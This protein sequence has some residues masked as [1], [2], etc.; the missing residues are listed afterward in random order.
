M[1]K[2]MGMS[3][4]GYW[5]STFA[6]HFILLSIICV[7]ISIFC[8]VPL[9]QQPYLTHC[10]YEIFFVFMLAFAAAS[11]VFCLV[12][13]TVC[14]R[15]IVAVLVIII[16]WT[17]S[18]VPAF[19]HYTVW[20]LSDYS[21]L[22]KLSSC[23]FSP[24]LGLHLGLK[25]IQ[26]YTTYGT[27]CGCIPYDPDEELTMGAVI[28]TMIA[29]CFFYG[30][31]IWYLD[32]VWPWQP[33]GVPRP[34]YFCFEEFKKGV[35]SVNNASLNIYSGEITAL[36]GHNGAGKTTTMNMITGRVE[37]NGHDIMTDTKQARKSLGLCPQH[38][39]LY[40]FMTVA[41][42][43]RFYANLKGQDP[44]ETEE[45]IQSMLSLLHLTE[46]RNVLASELSGG[47]QRKLCLGIAVIGGSK[48]IILDEPTAGMDPEARRGVWDMLLTLRQSGD[49]TILLTTHYMEEADALGDRIAIMAAGQIYCA[50]SPMFLKRMFGAGYHLRV[51]FKNGIERTSRNL[52]SLKAELSRQVPKVRME[53]LHATEAMFQ[54]G[55]QTSTSQLVTLFT[56]LEEL[57]EE[58]GLASFG[59]SVT[60]LEDVFLKVRPDWYVPGI[61]NKA[62][63]Q[64]ANM[65]LILQQIRALFLKR[66]QYTRRHLISFL[67]QLILP[68]IT[69][70]LLVHLAYLMNSFIGSFVSP[71][72]LTF[73]F[74]PLYPNSHSFY[75][76]N[77]TQDNLSPLY[78]NM[79]KTD[80]DAHTIQGDVDQY[81]INKG[82]R[83]LRYYREHW[84]LGATTEA[85]TNK[86]ASVTAWFNNHPYHAL[87]ISTQLIFEALLRLFTG[88]YSAEL[89]FTN[90]PFPPDETA[91]TQTTMTLFI[92]VQVAIMF[93]LF[94]TI[95]FTFLGCSFILLPVHERASKSK[96]LQLMTG[97]QAHLFWGIHFLYDFAIMLICSLVLIAGFTLMDY[98][99]VFVKYPETIWY[100]FLL[101][102]MFAWSVLPVT[103]LCSFLASRPASGFT[104]MAIV[105]ITSG[106][107]SVQG[108]KNNSVCDVSGYQV[109]TLDGVCLTTIMTG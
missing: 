39:I 40:E 79:L 42:H 66:L 16:A 28:L 101:L 31:V 36:L 43:L 91:D 49:K 18:Y 69:I 38:N 73:A 9:N 2:M 1:M 27:H 106:L 15:P 32:N 11:T 53:A 77:L 21:M 65:D 58:L 70:I 83:A 88:D 25:V 82:R 105:N 85:L 59:V 71:P 14:S 30:I 50:G 72:P 13:T 35:P 104:L 95:A 20:E 102:A 80:S 23:F 29:S 6:G 17:G 34:F 12:F 109:V 103:Y 4:W 86:S 97:L 94:I 44:K 107:Y 87:A 98:R 52:E 81:L 63:T 46:K 74:H 55:G 93:S 99:Q 84:L 3:D 24:T 45:E 33:V 75:G 64:L 108:N 56:R 19:T 76:S 57:R 10:S 61:T 96:L 22:R 26:V 90:H 48:V 78:T 100:L 68:L 8:Y 89:Q 92:R 5:L 7:A 67:F 60:T 47:M 54:L 51:A 62:Q 41:E 37:I